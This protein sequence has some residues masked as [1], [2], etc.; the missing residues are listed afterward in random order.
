[1]SLY[2]Y[3][4]SL[5][6]SLSLLS[7][8]ALSATLDVVPVERSK[9]LQTEDVFTQPKSFITNSQRFTREDFR[10]LP[11][12]NA[13]EMLDYA[14][15]AFTQTQGRKSPYFASIRAGS[16]LGII[17]DGAYLPPPAASKVLMQLPVNAIESMTV[18]RDASALNLGPLTSIIGP[19]TNSRTEGFIVIQTRSAFD[20]PQTELHSKIGSYQQFEVDASHNHAFNEAVAGRVLLAHQ[21]KEGPSDYF[22]DYQRQVGLWKLQGYHQKLDWQLNFWHADAEQALQRGLPSSGVSDAKWRYK[23]MQMRMLNGQAGYYWDE[24]STSAVR[25]AYSQSDATLQQFSH[26]QVNAYKEERTEEN[27]ANVDLSHALN[28]SLFSGKNLLRFGYNFMHY[29]NP[30]G[31][32]YYPG[33]AR[34]EHIHALYLQ[35][36]FRTQRASLDFGLRAD[37]RFIDKGYEQVGK[38]RRLIEDVR[39]DPLLTAALGA[40]F[41]VTPQSLLTARSLYT[42]QQPLSVYSANDGQLAKEQRL[43][44]ELGWQHHWWQAA[45]G[46]FTTTLT[47]FDEQLDNGAYIAAQID[48]PQDAN[49]KINVYANADWRNYGMELE[50]KGRYAKLHYELGFSQVKPG[51]TPNGVVNVPETLVRARLHYLTN[52]WQYS[53]GAQN[54]GEY[55]S[56]NQAGTGTAGGF[57][58]Y[59]AAL[60]YLFKTEGMQHKLLFSAKN[61]GDQPYETVYGFPSEGLTYGVDYYVQF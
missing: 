49:S 40:S 55:L 36:E 53:L 48:D 52:Q 33:F 10:R 1:M 19:M 32:L 6:F 4:I 8:I 21:Q 26:S 47:G 23:P 57:T 54:M 16:N 7:G 12:A 25:F 3:R 43:R 59:D 2:L 14:T 50:L 58:R 44:T 29:D 13:Y 9:G 5:T 17:L 27:F 34:K 15:G 22:N 24:D 39:L 56:A 41:Q 30:T 31:M 61:L 42:E 35:N 51:K 20:Q 28:R 18:V 60:A 11:V 37:Q 46:H 45:H 38:Q